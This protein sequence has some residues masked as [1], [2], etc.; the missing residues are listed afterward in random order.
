MLPARGEHPAWIQPFKRYAVAGLAVVI[1]LLINLLLQR[2]INPEGFYLLFF[3]AIMVSAWYGGFGPGMAATLLSALLVNAFLFA[4]ASLLIP[5][6]RQAVSLSIFI[7]E[8]T[9]ISLLNMI[10]RHTRASLRQSHQQHADTLDAISEGFF[11]VDHQWRVTHVNNKFEHLLQRQRDTLIGRTLWQAFPNFA[12]TFLPH[13]PHDLTEIHQPFYTEYFCATMQCWLYIHAYPTPAG[14]SVYVQDITARKHSEERNRFQ[15]NALNQ[16][17]DAV[18][19]VDNTY[20]LTYWNQRAVHLCGIQG[21]QPPLYG[22]FELPHMRWPTPDEQQQADEALQDTGTWSGEGIFTVDDADIPVEIT[23]NSLFDE[24]RERIGF[25]VVIRDASQRKQAEAERS[26]LLGREHTARVHAELAQRRLAFLAQASHELAGSLDY[27]TTLDNLLHLI[28]PTLADWCAVDIIDDQQRIDRVALTHINPAL[29]SVLHEIKRRY[30]LHWEM[31]LPVIETLRSGQ[32]QFY[33]SV[34]YEELN[35]VVAPGHL[36]LLH[37]VGMQSFMVVPL[38]AR[39]AIIGALTLTFGDSGR[40]Y[41]TDDRSLAEDLAHRAAFAVD[42]ARLYSYAHL[43][44]AEASALAGRSTFLAEVSRILATSLDY[45]ETLVAVARLVVP[46]LADH[47]MIDLLQ[48]DDGLQRIEVQQNGRFTPVVNQQVY[49]DDMRTLVFASPFA[50]V[51][52]TGR[53]VFYPEIPV[54]LRAMLETAR[55]NNDES[56]VQSAMIVPLLTREHM[57]GTITCF[58]TSPERH[59]QLTDLTLAEDLAHRVALAVDNAR[60][61]HEVQ[62][63]VHIRDQFLSIASHELK[64][65]LTSLLGYARLLQS[66]TEDTA[67]SERARRGVRIIAEQSDRLNQLICAL[68]DISR[69]R[70]GRLSIEQKPVDL[71]ALTRRVV[72]ETQ[73]VLERHTLQ[74]QASD[75]ELIVEG[76]TL[77]IEQVLQNLIQNA[78]KYSPRGGP[79]HVQLERQQEGIRLLVIDQGIGIPPEALSQMFQPFYRAPSVEHQQISGIGIGLY[80]VKE[81]V[82]LH[83]GSVDVE[84]QENEGSTFIVW[85]PLVSA[86]EQNLETVSRSYGTD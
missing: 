62:E 12:Q 15:A 26:H 25:L 52:H 41:T 13:L 37:Q 67:L 82:T 66:T 18:I 33:P 20:Q 70:M 42:N 28:V 68:L 56:S 84:S 30:P 5:D 3:G 65:P 80:V 48:E 43:A 24:H 74:L 22:L 34:S 69:I 11:A 55:Q 31:S 14:L 4:P 51:V 17:Q 27:H 44:R 59:Y 1:A 60:L 9:L 46:F 29:Q 76:D 53:S 38:V 7:I 61:Y 50:Y 16:V 86:V 57:L 21:T 45:N 85:L 8:G 71:V 23:I 78:I 81:I 72:Q 54:E 32:I 73:I 2:T 47:C 19:A 79:V 64:T 39:G 40:R 63:A 35:K 49:Y 36:E 10:H 77:R 83:G 58:S 6:T 75:E